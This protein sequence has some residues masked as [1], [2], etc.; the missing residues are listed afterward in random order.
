M[1][2]TLSF[3]ADRMEV[4]NYLED[5]YKNELSKDVLA[6]MTAPQKTI[7]SK[8]FYDERGSR[9][10]EKICHLSEYYQTRTEMDILNHCAPS[11]MESFE[12]GDLVELGSGA[13]WKIRRLL[14]SVETSEQADI[15]YVPVDVS[16][17]ALLS[18]SEELLEL[19]N[20]LK[21][22]GIIADFTKQISVIS[23]DRCKRIL[24]LGSTIGN[25][26]EE[27]CHQFLKDISGV[28]KPDDRCLIG[29][30][31]VK[32]KETLEQAYNDSLGVTSEFNKN[33]LHV[34]NRD[35]KG[36]F[37][38][39]HFDHLAYFNDEQSQVEMHLQANQNVTAEI[40]TLHLTVELEKGETI[41]TEICRKFTLEQAEKMYS[42]AGL[43]VTNCFSDSRGWFCVTELARK[44]EEDL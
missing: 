29:M 42:R 16:E 6:G 39:S 34:L 35:L 14:N 18:A 9:L 38:L 3:Q 31:M 26:N 32:D 20:D 4:R 12:E 30:D 41:H 24:F 28:M 36:D 43:E 1:P 22:L 37:D 33:V 21:V 23:T 27:E 15:R 7:P 17:A 13:N 40:G 8:Y 5:S 10:F 19:Y 11:I 2:T 25:L 44:Q